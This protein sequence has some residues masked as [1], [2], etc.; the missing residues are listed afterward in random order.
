MVLQVLKRPLAYFVTLFSVITVL[1][2]ASFADA[3]AVGQAAPDFTA[4]DVNGNEVKLSSLKGK[5]VVLEWF[6]PECPFVVKHYNSQNMQKTQKAATDKGVVWLSIN[7][8]ALGLQGNMKPE[9]AKKH[10]ADV[11]AAASHVILD[12]SGKIGGLYAAKTTPHMFVIDKEGKIAYMGAIDSISSA[13]PADIEKAD[14]YVLDAID[15]L[16][17]GNAPAVPQTQPYGCSVKY[18]K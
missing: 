11:K 17:K 7:S 3:P 6:N 16:E 12:P 15:A 18:A 10:M 9:E 8:S 13:D 4:T 1:A 2:G 14:N 5:V